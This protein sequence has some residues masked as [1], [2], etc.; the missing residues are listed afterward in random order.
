MN[1]DRI[2]SAIDEVLGTPPFVPSYSDLTPPRIIECKV[3]APVKWDR[4][5]LESA[6]N[7]KLP[8]DLVGLWEIASEIRLYDDVNYGQ[9]GC[10]LWSPAQI[11]DRHHHSL[12]WRGPDD[13]RP[14]DLI[15]GEFR[16][17]TD[18]VVLRCDAAEPDFGSVV[19]ALGMDPRKDWPYVASSLAE[20]VKKF[21]AD[22]DEKY[23]DRS[24]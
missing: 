13:F 19:I 4:K 14:G 2:R 12:G 8:D 15:I 22:P 24:D 5:A 6:L 3:L 17:E 21:L 20:F 16:G 1:H 10:I 23:W 18:R 11:V 9:W 7:V